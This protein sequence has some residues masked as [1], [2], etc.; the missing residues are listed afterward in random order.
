MQ[1]IQFMN[2]ASYYL[3]L[4]FAFSFAVFPDN[5]PAIIVLLVFSLVIQTILIGKFKIQYNIP[6]FLLLGFYL[7]NLLGI[8]W[9]TDT[10]D[11]RYSLETKLPMVLFPILFIFYRDFLT[12]NLIKILLLF[13]TGCTVSSVIC[14]SVAFWESI[15]FISGNMVFN[16]IDPLH[17]SWAYGGS[18]FMYI[19]LSLF[20]HPTYF[21]AYLLFSVCACIF[22]LRKKILPQK[23]LNRYLYVSIF[24][25]L[26]MIYLLSSKSGLI[27]TMLVLIFNAMVQIKQHGRILNKILILAGS[28]V[29]ILLALQNPR[30]SSI[31]EVI[32]NPNIVKNYATTGSVISRVHIWKVGID[33]ISQNFLTGVGIGDTEDELAR[34]YKT[35]NYQELYRQKANAHSQFFETFIELGLIGFLLLMALLIYPIKQSRDKGNY[36][37]L[38]FLFIL[39]F[40][41]LFESMLSKISGAIF[42]GFF[43]SVLCVID[44]SDLK[45]K[46]FR[47]NE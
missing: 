27:C 21:A 24:L 3:T 10:L 25:F 18:H 40:N 8:F 36:L 44:N 6:L 32:K 1:P 2:N 17:A 35:Y 14:L 31:R 38:F 23:F 11:A 34:K 5:M 22:L 43:Y 15:S 12:K 16:P 47:I 29:L 13:I 28:F 45:F 4:F 7:L 30:F 26:I 9:S 41:F 46:S 42:F 33:I 37:F 19:N 39:S 20:L